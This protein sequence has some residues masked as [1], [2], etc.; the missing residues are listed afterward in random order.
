MFIVIGRGNITMSTNEFDDSVEADYQVY[1]PETFSYVSPDNDEDNM[2]TN[3]HLDAKQNYFNSLIL[4]ETR[5]GDKTDRFESFVEIIVNELLQ[6]RFNY[7]L[8][9]LHTAT[10]KYLEKGNI[11]LN[12]LRPIFTSFENIQI[13]KLNQIIEGIYYK[14]KFEEL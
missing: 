8:K 11:I 2:Y 5:E 14:S 7:T 13:R 10:E 9:Q 12:E 4:N 1:A 6:S 3:F